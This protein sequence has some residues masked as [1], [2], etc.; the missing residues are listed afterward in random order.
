M[1]ANSS[2]AE[3]PASENKFAYA[4]GLVPHS[5]TRYIGPAFVDSLTKV[6]CQLDPTLIL[7]WL[8]QDVPCT[9][10]LESLIQVVKAGLKE[11][12]E[13]E[14]ERRT[15]TTPRSSQQA[16]QEGVKV[17]LESTDDIKKRNGQ[18]T[19]VF[20]GAGRASKND[21]IER[22]QVSS[23]IKLEVVGTGV[24]S[25]GRVFIDLEDD[26]TFE[27][28]WVCLRGKVTELVCDGGVGGL[29]TLLGEALIKNDEGENTTGTQ[30]C[31][32]SHEWH[33]KG[34]RGL[35]PPEELPRLELGSVSTFEATQNVL[36]LLEDYR[37]EEG[38]AAVVCDAVALV[39]VDEGG[40]AR[41]VLER[42]E[43]A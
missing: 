34:C 35:A 25:D 4:L 31:N 1:S 9:V 3:G 13:K 28:L 43:L 36:R 14:V 24:T 42:V 7:I 2:L 11:W 39:K 26:E 41:E 10:S 5:D 16:F 40:G 19:S 30:G 20:R 22:F 15:K 27:S 29:T 12:R 32:K 38:D 37:A 23:K 18:E 6:G 17:V 8:F 21:L 33:T